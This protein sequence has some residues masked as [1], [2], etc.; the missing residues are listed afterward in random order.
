[1]GKGGI[2]DGFAFDF[3]KNEWF[4]IENEL[5]SHSV[6]S[7]IA[8]QISRYVVSAQ[9][10]RTRRQIRDHVFTQIIERGEIEKF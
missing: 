1:M 9:N 2:P 5:L 6:W 7:H 10:P 4:V 3:A 8:E